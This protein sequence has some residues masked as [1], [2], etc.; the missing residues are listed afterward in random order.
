MMYLLVRH[1]IADFAKWKVVYDSH[2]P[3]RQAAGLVEEHIWHNVDIKNEVFVLS[4]VHDLEKARAFLS[5]ADLREAMERAGV[6]D[7][8]NVYFLTR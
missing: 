3:I 1:K 4:A 6:I 2:E 5:S 7:E 8:P